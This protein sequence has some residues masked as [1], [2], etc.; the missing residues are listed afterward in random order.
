MPNRNYSTAK[1]P[2]YQISLPQHREESGV[3]L[4]AL[5]RERPLLA[6][7][8]GVFSLVE[9]GLHA[10]VDD[11]PRQ[12]RIRGAVTE[13]EEVVVDAA[14]G[15]RGSPVLSVALGGDNRRRDAPVAEREQRL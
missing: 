10:A 14:V 6:E 12:H 2:D 11:I 5:R 4:R 9:G 3:F 7:P 13:H 8:L 15:N 1:L